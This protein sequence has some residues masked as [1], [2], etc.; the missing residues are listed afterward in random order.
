[1]FGVAPPSP[2]SHPDL[3]RKFLDYQKTRLTP[4]A[5][6][7]ERLIIEKHLIPFFPTDLRE[8]TSL[9]VE[10]YI[11]HRL[12]QPARSKKPGAKT[13]SGATVVKERNS[14]NHMFRWAIKNRSAVFNPWRDVAPPRQNRPRNRW[15][16]PVQVRAILE[17]SP[18]WLQPIIG[19]AVSTGMRRA[20]LLA[21]HHSEINL[22]NRTA[23]LPQTKNGDSRIVRLNDFALTVLHSLP[24]NPNPNDLLFP[25]IEP[26]N[27]SGSFQ[28]AC[29]R[30]GI[31]GFR[32]HDLRHTFSTYLRQQGAGLDVIARAVGHRSLNMASRYAHVNDSQVQAAV[33]AF[34]TAFDTTPVEKS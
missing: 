28:R 15:L 23:F 11:A 6:E 21:L 27:V 34:D 8:I 14:G 10:A 29:R 25:A 32:F 17:N 33:D 31:D 4:A 24:P 12:V 22:E 18:Y 2:G 9:V 16:T 3:C 26:V 1:M 20:E 5:Y 19:L 7:R 13:V 30:A